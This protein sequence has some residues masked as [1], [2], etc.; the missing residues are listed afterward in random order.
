MSTKKEVYLIGDI[1]RLVVQTLMRNLKDNDIEVFPVDPS[2]SFISHIPDLP[3]HV[4]LSLSED[5]TPELLHALKTKQQ[6]CGL[7]IYMAGTLKALS[8]VQEEYIKQVPAFRFTTW[9]IDVSIL[10]K[11]IEWHERT[12]KRILV[13]DDDPNILRTIKT[14]LENE[15]EI[16]LVNSGFNAIDFI[17]KHKVD[18]VLLDYEMPNLNGPEVLKKL[19]LHKESSKL[20]VIFLTAKGDRDSVMA[21]IEQ[22]AD[23][24]ILKTRKPAEIINTIREF[25][26]KYIVSPEVLG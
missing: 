6:K 12:R 11:A 14:W 16:Y 20:P 22:K 13:V 8:L 7:H 18:L 9:P 24:Y 26:K 10:S 2:P 21:A 23:G 19:R 5:V 17:A 4:M 25:F 15:Y 1:K 3:V